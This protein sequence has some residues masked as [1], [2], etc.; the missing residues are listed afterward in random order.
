MIK[1]VFEMMKDE[2]F[3]QI[4]YGYDKNSGM[5]ALISIHNTSLGPA[6]GGTRMMP[7]ESEDDALQ[8]VMKL[9]KAMTWKNAACGIDFGGGKAVII[10]DARKEKTE[11]LLRAFGRMVEGLG[12]RYITGV[13]I[14]TDENDMI[15]VRKETQYNV[16]LPESYGGG[17]STS[18]A[19]AF[20]CFEGIKSAVKEVFDDKGLK[21]KR[22]AIQGVGNI[23]SVLARYLVKEGAE[24]IVSD[25]NEEAVQRLCQELGIQQVDPEA[26]YDLEVD[27]FSPCALG[28]IL[29][30]TTIPRLQCR[31]VAGSANNQL[32][33]E[34]SHA[35]LLKERGIAYAV[36]F[37]MSAGGVINNSHQF[38]GYH[39][40]RAYGQV[41]RIG[42][43]IT[44]VF[45]MA[46]EKNVTTQEA[47]MMLARQRIASAVQRKSYYLEK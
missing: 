37:I 44:Q 6:F 23:G 3:E 12:G 46:R 2:E 33:D 7:Y 4:V 26:I 31:L 21:N 25:V 45:R 22:V 20:G 16:A 36:D 43:A 30:D 38:I 17:G 13:D 11:D 41:A 10:G 35:T 8:D 9:G 39:R 15:I 19:T 40:E 42:D 29:N 47:A 1:P 14:G 5:K 34:E 28:G 32:A 27:I 24:V 18:A